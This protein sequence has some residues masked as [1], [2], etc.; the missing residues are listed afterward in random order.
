MPYYE[1]YSFSYF[2]LIILLFFLLILILFPNYTKKD[3]VPPLSNANYVIDPTSIGNFI[4]TDT[5]LS[6]FSDL[7]IQDG[8]SGGTDA[9][10]FGASEGDVATVSYIPYYEESH[11]RII[12]FFE[13]NIG[14]S[15]S[16]DLSFRVVDSN[17]IPDT[18]LSEYNYGW[19]SLNTEAVSGVVTPVVTNSTPVYKVNLPFNI[20]GFANRNHNI[21]VQI[22]AAGDKTGLELSSAY[23]YYHSI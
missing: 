5:N 19:T 11:K 14:T 7:I 23:L 8:A 9:I 16:R 6:T 3:I 12:G 13:L 21:T 1:Y 10:D 22:A 17:Q 15:L 18:S 4:T 20:P 2:F